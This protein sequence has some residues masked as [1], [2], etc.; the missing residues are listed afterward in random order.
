MVNVFKEELLFWLSICAEICFMREALQIATSLFL[1]IRR[2]IQFNWRNSQKA[3]FLRFLSALSYSLKIVASIMSEGKGEQIE[4]FLTWGN[5]S[6]FTHFEIFVWLIHWFQALES[7]SHC[8]IL[9]L[10]WCKPRH[11]TQLTNRTLIRWGNQKRLPKKIDLEGMRTEFTTSAVV[12]LIKAYFISA[13][14]MSCLHEA[15]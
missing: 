9:E 2:I 7:M 10:C 12:A 11:L 6:K 1:W 5:E 8:D 13:K 3:H 4:D 14:F 15:V